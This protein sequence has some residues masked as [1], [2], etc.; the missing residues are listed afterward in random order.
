MRELTSSLL[1]AIS[2]HR[3]H[4]IGFNL[5]RLQRA[6]VWLVLVKC[7]FFQDKTAAWFMVWLVVS[8]KH[9]FIINFSSFSFIMVDG[10]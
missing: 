10:H 9:L 8:L 7:F 5:S 4:Q 3:L 1:Y 2:A 6:K